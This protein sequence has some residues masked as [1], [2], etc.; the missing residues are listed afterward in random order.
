M[1]IAKEFKPHEI[2][3]YKEVS[4]SRLQLHVFFPKANKTSDRRPAIVFFFGGGWKNGSPAQFYPQCEH[5]AYRGI[6]AISAEYRVES[7]HRTSPRESVIDGKSAIRWVRQH[8]MELGVDPEQIVAGGGSAGAHVAAATAMIEG[9]EQ[10]GED[11]SVSCRPNALVLFNPVF[12]NGPN[13][14][15]Y[16]RVKEYWEEFS[17]LHNIREST[18]P[19]IVLLGTK[20]NLVPVETAEAYKDQM[21][22]KGNRC[23]LYLFEGQPHGFFNY[24]NPENF[25]GTVDKMDQFLMSIGFL[26]AE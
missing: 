21:E 22:I 20:D 16:D 5:L 19:T 13:G 25:A 6:V 14:Y 9:F 23:D 4:T 3:P 18:P 12:D 2:I 7:L 1:T 10:P 17:P 26:E 15:G 8:A 24:N 11:T